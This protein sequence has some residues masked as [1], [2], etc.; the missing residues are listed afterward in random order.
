MARLKTQSS[1]KFVILLWGPAMSGKTV[2]ASQ[3]PNPY[4]IDLD[5][6]MG[7]VR[8][9]SNKY[10]MDFDFPVINIDS[11]P[12]EDEDFIALCGDRFAKMNAW[13]KTKKLV[14]K[15][16]QTLDENSTLVLDNLSRAS[17]YLLDEIKERTGRQQLQ[18]QDWGTFVD[19]MK[20]LVDYLHTRY[21]KC[22]TILIG[23]E[24]SKKDDLSGEL[25]KSLLMP[26]SLS[27]R[28]PSK[29][30][31]FLYMNVAATGPKG[32]RVIS[33]T[34]QSVPDPKNSVG[35]RCLI[36]NLVNPTYAKM[37]PLIEAYLGRALG[38]PTWTPPDET[39]GDAP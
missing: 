1:S 24:S 35:S 25:F 11:S 34:L 38:E 8:A 2:L 28:M 27:D 5:G 19:E 30:S 12:T 31:D 29:V 17:E 6:Q 4:F 20:I 16:S 18:I 7:S 26:T 3:F 10:K 36:P 21:T 22:N 23:H 13:K 32:K 9:L 33:R 37:R 15:L 39:L 14:E